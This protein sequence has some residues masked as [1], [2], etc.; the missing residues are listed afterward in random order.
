MCMNC[1]SLN[2]YKSAC[3]LIQVKK[4]NKIKRANELVKVWWQERIQKNGYS[5]GPVGNIAEHE[6]A[7][8]V[9]SPADHEG[10]DHDS[11]TQ[12]AKK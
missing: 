5:L 9:R 7:S 8:V 4:Q 3:V 11:C 6:A 2:M 10:D 1:A 12:E